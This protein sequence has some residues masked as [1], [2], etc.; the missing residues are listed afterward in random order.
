MRRRLIRIVRR[1][2]AASLVVLVVPVITLA[3][4]ETTA[5]A[6]PS[7][8]TIYVNEGSF[9][10]GFTTLESV[11]LPAGTPDIATPLGSGLLSL[12]SL[13]GVGENPFIPFSICYTFGN[14]FVLDAPEVSVVVPNS[15]AACG[16]QVLASNSPYIEV[17]LSGPGTT[18][19]QCST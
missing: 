16:V 7:T 8:D 2:A 6:T 15:H 17:G 3:L 4:T 10:P 19:Q 14:T 11:P 18:P 5:S 13:G 12:C 9:G 1:L